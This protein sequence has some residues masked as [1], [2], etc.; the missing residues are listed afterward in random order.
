VTAGVLGGAWH[1]P[2]AGSADPA[3]PLVT[4]NGPR[5]DRN[6]LNSGVSSSSLGT[7]IWKINAP[8]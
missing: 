8:S 5:L 7:T 1:T 6:T 2:S 4:G 3:D